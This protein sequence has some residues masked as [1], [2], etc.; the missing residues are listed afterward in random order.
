MSNSHWI[1]VDLG[2]TK[3]LAGVFDDDCK[4]L[5]QRKLPTEADQGAETVFGQIRQAVEGA[6]EQA[7]VKPEQVRGLGMGIPGQIDPVNLRVRYA[8]NLNWRDLDLMPHVK[9]FWSFPCWFHNDV[10]MG[11]YGEFTHGAAQGARHVLGIFVGTGVG[12]GLILNGEIFHGFN[13]NAGEIGH[14]IVHWR[15]GTELESIAGRRA[16]M[17]RV[18]ELLPD[19]PKKSRKQ[20]KGIDPTAMKSSHL[21]KM[22]NEGDLLT[23]Q[24]V[25]DA[26]RALGAA[27]GSC[28]NLLS[29]EVIVLGGGV[30]GALGEPFLERIWE[31]AQ[32]YALPQATNGVRLVPAALEDISGIV[33]AAAWAKTRCEAKPGSKRSAHKAGS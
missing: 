12:G 22:Y 29:P 30:A 27:V 7:G 28:V 4:L 1:G 33:G 2:G 17:G 32:R 8:P 9:P 6:L 5:A 14:I 31:V 26:A 13:F 10:Q 23:L 11:T 16:M 18:T 24:L 25:D 21:A 20:W 3:V 15:R 19:A